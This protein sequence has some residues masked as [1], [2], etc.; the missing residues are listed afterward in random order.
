MPPSVTSRQ[1]PVILSVEFKMSSNLLSPGSLAF[2]RTAS[3][4]CRA[5]S[6]HR[7]LGEDHVVSR[8]PKGTPPDGAVYRPLSETLLTSSGLMIPHQAPPTGFFQRPPLHR[9]PMRCPL[10]HIASDVLRRADANRHTC[11][12]YVGSH[13]LDGL[14]HRTVRKLVASCCRPWGSSGF[15]TGRSRP[16][17]PHRCHT[18]QSLPLPSS[19]ACRH[20]QAAA[21]SSLLAVHQTDLEALL[22]SRV[23]CA[24]SPLPATTHPILSW[25]SLPE[26]SRP[27]SLL[28]T[29]TPGA[30]AFAGLRQS[31]TLS[32]DVT[33]ATTRDPSKR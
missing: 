25:A 23:R 14:L 11:S 8:S 30:C 13:H 17:C 28:H 4:P 6:T 31:A 3:S 21:S 29:Y 33:K 9:L 24:L 19:R 26:A 7:G 20:R 22:H 12:A 15:H 10:P 16:T 32:P 2:P 18:L 27:S 1:A 5:C